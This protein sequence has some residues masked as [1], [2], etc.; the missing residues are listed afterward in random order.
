MLLNNVW[1]TGNTEPVDITVH[2]Q[3]ITS[4]TKAG[5]GIV[6]EDVK[7]PFTNAIAFPGLINSHEHLDFNCFPVLNKRTYNNYTEWGKHIHSAYKD[8]INRVLKIPQEL[9]AEWGIYKNLLAG[10]TT[11]VNHGA[12][13]PIKNPLINIVQD[14]ASLHSVQFQKKW[15]WKLN[16]LFQKNRLYVIH[17]GEGVDEQS[18]AEIDELLRWNLFNRKLVGVHAVAMNSA[19]AK[20]F[21]GIVWCPESN[22]VLLNR[23]ADIAQLKRNT[24]LVFGTDSTL[25]GHWNIWQ[26]L[27]LARGLQQVS[28]TE[29]FSMVTNAPAKL[30]GMNNGEL[31]TGKDADIVIAGTQNTRASLDDLFATNPEDILLVLHKGHIRLFDASLY[32]AVSNHQTDLT[33]FKPVMINDSVKYVEGDLPALAGAIRAYHPAIS[34]PFD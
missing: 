14:T 10:V 4:I 30:W 26:H 9:R 27:R 1:H 13:L 8:D 32:A 20:K 33:P 19:Q 21:A 7:I 28:D 17:T 3:K 25:T 29:L 11:V 18:A 24:Q 12:V 34:F 23:H 22:H 16:T 15:K 5:E 31:L 2:N 6:G